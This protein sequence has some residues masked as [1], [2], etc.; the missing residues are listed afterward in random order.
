MIVSTS[1]GTTSTTTTQPCSVIEEHALPVSINPYHVSKSQDE[2]NDQRNV[3]ARMRYR[4]KKKAFEQPVSKKP[5]LSRA[6]EVV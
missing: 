3:T 4:A 2:R 6:K 1:T 5:E